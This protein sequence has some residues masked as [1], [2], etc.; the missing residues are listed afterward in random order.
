MALCH[1]HKQVI[2]PE[3]VEHWTK[4]ALSYWWSGCTKRLQHI[5]TEQAPSGRIGEARRLFP[6][7]TDEQLMTWIPGAAHEVRYLLTVVPH[8]EGPCT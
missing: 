2:P 5:R 1:D 7:M 3:Q 4:T 8:A 6:H